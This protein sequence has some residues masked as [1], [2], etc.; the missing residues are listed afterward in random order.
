MT[1]IF[2]KRLSHFKDLESCRGGIRGGSKGNI[3]GEGL[4][5]G[6]RRGR[7]SGSGGTLVFQVTGG[8]G[9]LL[10]VLV[11]HGQG[12]TPIIFSLVNLEPDPD[13]T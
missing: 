1:D 13:L 5:E 2:L 8:R 6:G 3:G 9:S 11:G 12:F 4:R 10:R 7:R